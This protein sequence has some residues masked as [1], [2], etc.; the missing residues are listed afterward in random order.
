M[1]STVAIGDFAKASH[2]SVKTLRHYHDIGLLVPAEVDR[3]SGYRRYAVEQ[4]RTAQVIRRFRD[5]GMPLG[6]IA[7]VLAAPDASVRSEV[8]ASHL[9][10][11]ERELIETQQAVAALRDLLDGPRVA[12]P[13]VHRSEPAMDVAAILETVELD[14]LSAWFQGAVGELTA[15]LAAQHVMTDG[16]GG[17]VVS[18]EF[19]ADERGEIT[20]FVPVSASVRSVGRV[21]ARRLPPVEL[22]VIVHRGS[23]NDIDRSYG[24]LA[25]HVAHRAI[26]VDGPLRERY[27]IGR[28]NTPDETQ[29]RTEIGW[30]IFRAE[31]PDD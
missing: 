24:A 13:I 27:L 31:V 3:G 12:A 5:L 17:A 25:E 26:S 19:F 29:W 20:V 18:D 6:Q 7:D 2:L 8:I 10:R 16:P 11:L 22:A 21:V 28:E 9:D 14:S 4:V 15:T 30:P 1:T 23:H